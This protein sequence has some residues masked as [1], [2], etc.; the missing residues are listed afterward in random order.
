MG[1]I[2][3]KRVERTRNAGTMTESMFFGMIRS[4]LRQKSRWWKPIAICKQKARRLYKGTNKRQK[5]EY[6]CNICKE[7]FKDTDVAVD[8][9][10]PCGKLNSSGDLQGFVERLFVEEDQLQ[11][12]CNKCHSLKT[13]ED[14]WKISHS[15]NEKQDGL[16][17]ERP[18]QKKKSKPPVKKY[19]RKSQ[20]HMNKSISPSKKQRKK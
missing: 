4:A 19:Q 5:Y 16:E 1:A 15:Q 2:K 3:G 12:L 14:K 13:E 20:S 7:W 17:E 18:V 10:I 11:L 9:I 6:Q 8:H